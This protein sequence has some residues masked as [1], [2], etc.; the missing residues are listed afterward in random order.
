MCNEV[1]SGHSWEINIWCDVCNRRLRIR[2]VVWPDEYYV[3]YTFVCGGCKGTMEGS[4][5]TSRPFVPFWETDGWEERIKL[6]E[7]K[8]YPLRQ[9]VKKVKGLIG[10]KDA[11]TRA[12]RR[13]TVG[14]GRGG[15]DGEGRR[16]GGRIFDGTGSRRSSAR[17]IRKKTR[18]E[19]D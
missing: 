7:I 10:V 2:K 15:D 11:C 3:H 19:E 8:R 12:K 13:G 17:Y 18:G 6:P 16:A 1:N 4:A 9:K 5:I 14:V